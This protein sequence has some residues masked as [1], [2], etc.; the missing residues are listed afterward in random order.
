MDSTLTHHTFHGSTMKPYEK[1]YQSSTN[2]C[3]GFRSFIHAGPAVWCR[4]YP[5]NDIGSILNYMRNE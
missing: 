2:G 1:P 5:T 3:T 4:H